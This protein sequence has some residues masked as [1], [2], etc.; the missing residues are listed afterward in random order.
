MKQIVDKDTGGGAGGFVQKVRRNKAL[1]TVAAII[2]LMV[3]Y[4]VF[5]AQ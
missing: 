1:S 2:V 4:G 5:F 3:L